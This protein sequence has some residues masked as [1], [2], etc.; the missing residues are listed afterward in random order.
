MTV[1][2]TIMDAQCTYYTTLLQRIPFALWKKVGEM[3]KRM[4]KQ[5]VI[6]PSRSPWTSPIVLVAKKDGSTRLCVEY[7]KLNAVTKMDV[8]PLLS[9]DDSLD[10]LART[11]YFMTLDLVS[12]YWQVAMEKESREKTAFVIHAGLYEFLVMPFGLCNAPAT[13]QPLMETILHD[14]VSCIAYT[15]D[16]ETLEDH[17][18]NLQRVLQRL[19]EAG[20]KLKA[21]KCNLLWWTW[22]TSGILSLKRE[23]PLTIRR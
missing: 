15:D 13:F 12:G 18:H 23:L 14:L 19:Q 11:K 17:P 6:Q 16:V 20:L 7:R 22:S 8:F 4:L 10:L 2:G 1:N 3:V 5:G 21:R 9:I